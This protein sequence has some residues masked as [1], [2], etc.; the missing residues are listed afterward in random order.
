MAVIGLCYCVTLWH[1]SIGAG[2]VGTIT[3]QQ[4]HDTPHAKASAQGHDKGLQSIDCG[5]EKLHRTSILRGCPG[6]KI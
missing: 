6:Q 1:M 5:T 3:F 2:V 4:V